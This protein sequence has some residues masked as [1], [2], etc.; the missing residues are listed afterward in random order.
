MLD[1]RGQLPTGPGAY[2]QRD[3]VGVRFIA[4]HHSGSEYDSSAK[5][6]AEYHIRTYGWPGCGYQLVSRWDGTLEWVWDWTTMSYNVARRNHEVI[7]ICCPGDY[8]QRE[9]RPAQLR[10]A[11]D[12]AWWLSHEV[13]PGAQIVGHREIALPG[14]ETECPGRLLE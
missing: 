8:R 2:L 3:L 7:G 12:A 10:A 11:L 14:F 5:E 1:L 9:P 13:A 4:L 6:I